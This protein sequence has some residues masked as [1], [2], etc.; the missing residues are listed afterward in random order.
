MSLNT[1]DTEDDILARV[2]ESFPKTVYDVNIP[3]DDSLEYDSRGTLVPYAIVEWGDL[4]RRA[5][6]RGIVSVRQ[7]TY[8]YY[9]TV[10]IVAGRSSDAR[11]LMR[12]MT[13]KLTGYRPVDAGEIVPKA[14][15]S[16]ARSSAT[17]RPMQY[18]YS[19]TYQ[20]VTNLSWGVI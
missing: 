9:F 4:Q 6:D 12:V 3:E 20:C 11:R 10:T 2:K 19:T 18:I 1:S 5:G 14:S 8:N 16:F 15:M 17:N 7:D 13:D